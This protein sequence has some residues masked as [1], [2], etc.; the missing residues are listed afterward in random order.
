MI[1]FRGA[2]AVS[3]LYNIN[4]LPLLN[5]LLIQVKYTLI[6]SSGSVQEQI[7]LEEILQARGVNYSTVSHAVNAYKPSFK[8]TFV[9]NMAT[10][11]CIVA[12]TCTHSFRF[13]YYRREIPHK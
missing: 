12:Y 11:A 5:C 9:P 8:S 13:S 4:C 2:V 7:P 1:G 3:F 10:S 6:T